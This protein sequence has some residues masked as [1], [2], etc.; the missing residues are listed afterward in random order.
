MDNHTLEQIGEGRLRID[1]HAT[2]VTQ[3]RLQEA[4]E[5]LLHAKGDI[6]ALIGPGV[7]QT[8]L[9]SLITCHARGDVSHLEA[10]H[11][12]GVGDIE[13]DA[14]KEYRDNRELYNSMG[15]SEEQYVASR[16]RDGG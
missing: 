16:Q 3:D 14:R 7:F 13:A 8:V 1:N 6:S 9:S 15:V 11:G 5:A 10:V 12:T 2:Y 4:H